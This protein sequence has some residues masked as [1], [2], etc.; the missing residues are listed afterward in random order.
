ML[1]AALQFG[2]VMVLVLAGTVALH[3]YTAHD[4]AQRQLAEAQA[5]TKKLEEVV[6]RLTDEKRVADLIVTDE[7]T[8]DGVPHKTLLFVEYTRDGTSLTPRSFEIQGEMV[9]VDA[10]VIKFERHFV[11]ENDPLRGHSIALFTRIYGDHQTPQKA[12]MIDE[13]GKIPDIYRGADPRV[14]PFEQNL[15]TEFWR[16]YDDESFRAQKGVRTSSGQGVW[17]PFQR[18][19]LYTITLESDG[20]LS[21]TSSPLKAIYREA[22]RRHSPM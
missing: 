14:A 6:Q 8:V 18:D 9:H 1:R 19:K 22:L 21:L 5:Q 11:S 13:P 7:S 10:L 15:W 16:L 17:G 2:L 4:A 12:Q 3:W 20:G